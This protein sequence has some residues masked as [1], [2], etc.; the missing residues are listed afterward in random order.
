MSITYITNCIAID[1]SMNRESQTH[2]N[3]K[4][5]D[6]KSISSARRESTKFTITR[7]S[8]GKE[9]VQDESPEVDR[10]QFLVWNNEENCEA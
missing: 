8:D 7:L 2:D 6:P 3:M 10:S 4:F 1:T 9:R 5:Y